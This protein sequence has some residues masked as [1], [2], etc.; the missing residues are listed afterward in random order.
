[1]LK[2]YEAVVHGVP[3]PR[4]GRIEQPLGRH[5]AHRHK[6]AVVPGGRPS[7]TDYRVVEEFGS[8]YSRLRIQLHTGRTHQI[9]VHMAWLGH[10]VL[11][12]NVYGRRSNPFGL[13]GQFLH[14]RQ[15]GFVHP[16]TGS[17]L[18]FEAPLPPELAAV[19]EELRALP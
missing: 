4:Q 19:L 3:W 14:C 17:L 10:P 9:R 12:D 7:R 16:V 11:G 2:I 15:L 5:P 13:V 8:D 6:M 1:M 18:E